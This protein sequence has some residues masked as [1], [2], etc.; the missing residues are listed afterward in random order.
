MK[1]P[2]FVVFVIMVMA[3]HV[4]PAFELTRVIILGGMKYYP[5]SFNNFVAEIVSIWLAYPLTVILAML[6][7]I[8]SK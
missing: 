2:L 7:W 4:Y 1:K 3:L 8:Y 5:F 6:Y